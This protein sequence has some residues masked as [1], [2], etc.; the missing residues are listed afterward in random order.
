M[1]TKF[2][3]HISLEF[4]LWKSISKSH[5]CWAWV[6]RVPARISIVQSHSPVAPFHLSLIVQS[7]F[8]SK[9][10]NLG[11]YHQSVVSNPLIVIEQHRRPITNYPFNNIIS[12]DPRFMQ[13]VDCTNNLGLHARSQNNSYLIQSILAMQSFYNL[14]PHIIIIMTPFPFK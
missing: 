8:V 5:N 4:E 3:T 9:T 11:I 10:Y 2:Q 14:T 7:F 12:N 13:L 6:K 1:T